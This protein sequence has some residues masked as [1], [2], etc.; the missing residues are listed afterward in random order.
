[1]ILLLAVDPKASIGNNKTDTNYIGLKSEY[2]AGGDLA[3]YINNNPGLSGAAL[4]KLAHDMA[5]GLNTLEQQNIAHRDIKQ[6]NFGVFISLEGIT[7]KLFDFGN[8]VDCKD[9]TP[10]SSSVSSPKDQITRPVISKQRSLEAG[11]RRDFSLGNH[12]ESFT[13]S[14]VDP[15]SWTIT[16]RKP[17]SVKR[18]GNASVTDVYAYGITILEIFLKNR[19]SATI[20]D[21]LDLD[22]KLNPL[23]EQL[24]ILM[25]NPTKPR[26]A[27]SLSS[28]DTKYYE[29]PQNYEYTD[30]LA[31]GLKHYLEGNFNQEELASEKDPNNRRLMALRNCKIKYLY[32]IGYAKHKEKLSGEDLD[33]KKRSTKLSSN[34][35]FKLQK[36]K[37]VTQ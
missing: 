13:P 10:T 9:V 4:L 29:D 19:A 12:E 5:S 16:G 27:R 28:I 25:R 7:A 31:E 15:A 21:L 24:D 3:D 14:Y 17:Y 18:T 33:K 20:N 6:E 34:I 32:S 35:A 22:G 36:R 2:A 37:Q 11:Y 23:L 1:M 26:I 30:N 8:A